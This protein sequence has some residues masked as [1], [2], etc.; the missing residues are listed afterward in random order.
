[1]EDAE[2]TD[3]DGDSI[4]EMAD[5]MRLAS[6]LLRLAHS[7]GATRPQLIGAAVKIAASIA[8]LEGMTAEDIAARVRQEFTSRAEGSR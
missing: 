6:A 5:T 7:H 1:M 4:A 3:A 8:A 2:R